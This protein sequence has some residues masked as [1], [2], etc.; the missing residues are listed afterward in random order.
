ML[1][2]ICKKL[3]ARGGWWEDILANRC[4]FPIAPWN[5]FSNLAYVVAGVLAYVL[6]PTLAGL[7]M[8]LALTF[9]GVGSG[10]YHGYKTIQTAQLDH[11]GMYVAFTSLTIY[12]LSPTHPLIGPLMAIVASIVAWRLVYTPNWDKLLYS[13]VGVFIAISTLSVALNGLFWYAVMGFSTFGIAYAIWWADKKRVF[14][15]QRLGH[16][17]FHVLSA[18]ALLLLFIGR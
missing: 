3:Q 5:T 9:L 10:L 7:T 12:N 11:A 14:P 13:M 18:G 16:A 1:T 6:N 8:G 4:N 17:I 15:L 2:E